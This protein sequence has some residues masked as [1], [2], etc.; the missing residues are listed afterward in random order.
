MRLFFLLLS[1]LT[2]AAQQPNF[3][4]SVDRVIWVVDDMD[5]VIHGWDKLGLVTIEKRQDLDALV[6][7]RGN[8][9][10]EKIRMASG[11]FGD[12]RVE[13][14]QPLGGA[15]AYA[16]FQKRHGLGILSLVHR[17]PTLPEFQA[18]IERLRQAGVAVL[19]QGERGAV[20]YAYFDTEQAGKYVLGLICLPDGAEESA[21]P[22]G[23]KIVQFAFAVRD[24]KPISAFWEKVGFAP[25]AFNSS[26]LSDA[27]YRGTPV[28]VQQDVGWQRGRKIV[29]EWLQ[30]VSL[31]TLLDDHIK[32]RGEGIEHLAIQVPDIA[33]AVE[34][35]QA[36]GFHEYQSGAWGDVGKKGS[37]RF[38]YMDTESI[39]GL[40]IE[41]LWNFPGPS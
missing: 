20:H 25:M 23:T 21:A 12:V 11:F 40:V 37:G 14:I 4:K 15:T 30:P 24:L 7:F 2:A 1:V 10:K 16:D 17:V 8:Q 35:W 19:E 38:T 31:P 28:P 3:Y 39:G 22:A 6:E 9:V 5:R 41:L 13:W 27:R 33:K 34:E 26:H 18:E 29:Y 32:Q 36:L